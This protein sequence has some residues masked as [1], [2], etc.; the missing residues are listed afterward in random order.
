VCHPGATSCSNSRSSGQRHPDCAST[1]HAIPLAHYV[2][3]GPPAVLRMPDLGVVDA[4]DTALAGASVRL[5]PHFAGDVLGLV[6]GAARSARVRATWNGTTGSL[7]LASQ[8]A[9]APVTI[10]NWV[11]LLSN[12]LTFWTPSQAPR[13][14]ARSVQ[15]LVTDAGAN[16]GGAPLASASGA[17]DGGFT[18]VARVSVVS[19]NDPT[20]VAA[21]ATAL[22]ARKL[23]YLEGSTP[24]QL[25]PSASLSDADNSTL[26][27]ITVAIGANFEPGADRLES[28]VGTARRSADNSTLTLLAAAVGGGGSVGAFQAALRRVTFA[29]VRPASDATRTVTVTIND[30]AKSTALHFDVRIVSL[31]RFTVQ[32]AQPAARLQPGALLRLSVA[33]IGSEPKTFRWERRNVNT[34]VEEEWSPTLARDG[35]VLDFVH[36][37]F[38]DAGVDGAGAVYRCVVTNEAGAVPSAPVVLSV[39]ADSA[40]TWYSEASGRQPI[41]PSVMVQTD[42]LIL[43]DWMPPDFNGLGKHASTPFALQF[44]EGSNAWRVAPDNL[45]GDMTIELLNDED[46]GLSKSTSGDPWSFRVLATNSRGEVSAASSELGGVL[47]APEPPAWTSDLLPQKFARDPGQNFTAEVAASGQPQP[48]YQWTLNGVPL[49]GQVTR[50][51]NIT[52]VN[53]L[54]NDGEY[55]CIAKNYLAQTVSRGIKLKVNTLPVVHVF[56]RVPATRVFAGAHVLFQCAA[57]GTP[58]P[59][60]SWRRNG[61]A[62]SAALGEQTGNVW[63][64]K[65]EAPLETSSEQDVFQCVASNSV[66]TVVSAAIRL[67]M[68][69]CDRGEW[70]DALGYCHACPRGR[71]L[72]VS[73]HREPACRRCAP[74]HFAADPSQPTCGKCPIGKFQ[75]LEEMS[76]CDGCEPGRFA[77]VSGLPKCDGCAPGTHVNATRAAV[78]QACPTGQFESGSGAV[79]CQACPAGRF[80]D[81]RDG[82]IECAECEEGRFKATAGLGACKRCGYGMVSN[83]LRTACSCQVGFYF[84]TAGNASTAGGEGHGK[85]CVKCGAGMR[86][87]ETDIAFDAVRSEPGFWQV[88]SWYEKGEQQTLKMLKCPNLKDE[89]CL[90][91]N[92][93]MVA[94]LTCRAGHTGPLCTTCAPDYQLGAESLCIYCKE[95]VGISRTVVVIGCVS[96]V[97]CIILAVYAYHHNHDITVAIRRRWHACQHAVGAKHKLHSKSSP[98]RKRTGGHLGVS[99]RF[100]ILLGL[101]QVTTQFINNFDIA[102]PSNFA[103]A[104]SLFNFI[105][106]DLPNMGCVVNINYVDKFLSAV[107]TPLFM[108]APFALAFIACGVI[109]RARGLPRRENGRMNR[110]LHMR[111]LALKAILYLLFLVYPSTSSIILRMFHCTELKNGKS[112]LTADMSIECGSHSAIKT[113]MFGAEYS[114][115]AYQGWA[116]F[117]ILVYPIGVPLFFFLVL[118]WERHALYVGKGHETN[119]ELEEEL[120]FLYA[121]YERQYYWWE[122]V[123]CFRKLILTGMITFINPGTSSQL[124]SAVLLSQVFIVLYARQKPFYRSCDDNLMLLAQLQIWFTAI[125]GHSIKLSA[126]P[127]VAGAAV[128]SEYETAAFDVLMLLSVAA[129]VALSVWQTLYKMHLNIQKNR[130][131]L[132]VTVQ[133]AHAKR[134]LQDQLSIAIEKQD[135]DQCADLK[136]RIKKLGGDV[137]GEDAAGAPDLLTKAPTKPMLNLS[138]PLGLSKETMSL[139]HMGKM[140][141]SKVVL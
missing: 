59:T 96:F 23:K 111:N 108:G 117:T 54:D 102:W 5:R 115:A 2:E 113:Q 28:G 3:D 52:A 105:N 49:S 38:G 75:G 22:G 19:V 57:S 44:R 32:P 116:A 6:A 100:K 136:D 47:A 16:E 48:T 125:S 127:T 106:V 94:G 7:S 139:L 61:T 88:K 36:V 118:W 62:V 91:G 29:T 69:S 27:A 129:P 103:A 73:N 68:R 40:P 97:V 13:T 84:V 20:A 25:T 92:D 24:L 18:E 35:P 109:F 86:C 80:D 67:D 77:A 66:G 14:E 132:D 110:V 50:A 128:D 81:G 39:A 123:E 83:R 11:A 46:S 135:F 51:L 82:K 124:F 41:A 140:K 95:K 89:I 53:K 130:M 131:A 70:R 26:H 55:K 64:L 42:K 33:A 126:V 141:R 114:F 138:N 43:L 45:K 10:E 79:Q 34:D 99:M 133:Q 107:L 58:A 30:G 17:F 15:L 56:Q 63:K 1:G 78:C 104:V 137:V 119:R 31:A 112:Y 12:S 90:G 120:G 101:F 122:V 72:D 65:V 93:E 4:T 87:N 8:S 37:L 60:F 85:E 71:F 134:E 9:T 98:I 21:K 74:G 121:G 76:K